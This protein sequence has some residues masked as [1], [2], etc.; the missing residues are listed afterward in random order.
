LETQLALEEQLVQ[1]P[2]LIN[3]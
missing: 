2:K 3:L 1:C